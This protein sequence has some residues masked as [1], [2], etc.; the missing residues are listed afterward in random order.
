MGEYLNENAS[1]NELSLVQRLYQ[2]SET[3]GKRLLGEEKAIF[4]SVFMRRQELS[5]ILAN[6]EIFKQIQDVK[7]SIFYFGVYYGEGFMT[8]ANLCAAL[9]PFN[10]SRQIIGFDTFDGY[11]EVTAN[12]VNP[13]LEYRTMH[14]GG[15]A[16]NFYDVLNELIEIYDSNRPISQLTKAKLVKGDVNVTLPDYIEKNPHSVASLVVLTMNLYEPTKNA[17]SLLWP[18]MPKGGI[19]VMHSIDQHITPGITAALLDTIG[20]NHEIKIFPYAPNLAY[21]IKR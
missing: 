6:Y 12:D 18:R 17:L 21:I 16:S 2:L 13:Q 19:V 5:Y 14:A 8:Y 11:P 1:K 20:I 10:H 4:P 7:G 9:E 3:D 15:W